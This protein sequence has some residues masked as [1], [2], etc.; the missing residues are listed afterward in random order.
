MG[1]IRTIILPVQLS[2]AAVIATFYVPEDAE[3]YDYIVKRV[4][5]GTV[6]FLVCNY[7]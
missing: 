4:Q 6:A 5:I 3:H 1:P 7:F 2:A